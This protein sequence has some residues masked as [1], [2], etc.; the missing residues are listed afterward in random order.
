M[1]DATVTDVQSIDPLSP[2]RVTRHRQSRREEAR[3]QE[4]FIVLL[5]RHAD[6]ETTFYSSVENRPWNCLAGIVQRRRGVRAGLPDVFILHRGRLI[7]VEF[8]SRRGSVSPVQR[9]IREELLRAGASW[10]MARSAEAG[11]MA[12]LMDGVVFRRPWTLP[13]T[14]APWEGPHR[15]ATRLPVHPEVA[16]ERREAK[17]R[18]RERQ[19]ATGEAAA[20]RANGA[21]RLDVGAAAAGQVLPFRSNKRIGSTMPTRR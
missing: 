7:C 11:M 19:R 18:W 2:L 3:E 21:H 1:S 13:R 5:T 20:G 17:R 15:E 4:R 8:K 14:L 12:L 6:P 16:N 10:W 9:A